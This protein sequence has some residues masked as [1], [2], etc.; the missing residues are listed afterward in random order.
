MRPSTE[1]Q[2]VMIAVGLV[3]MAGGAVGKQPH[4]IMGGATA[5]AAGLW[6]LLGNEGPKEQ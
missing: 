3:S 6:G 1:T 5:T 4:L 2:L